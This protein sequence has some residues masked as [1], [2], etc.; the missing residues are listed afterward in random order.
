VIELKKNNKGFTLIELLAVIVI[1][2][3]IMLVAI[4]S[5]MSSMER[6]KDKQYEA[7]KSIIEAKA[8]LYVSDHKNDFKTTN[9]VTVETLKNEGLLTEKD[10]MD[11]R[12]NNIIINGYVTVTVTQS[13]SGGYIYTYEFTE[14]Q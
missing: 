8:E 5:I 14:A 12:N 2:I 11:P 3:A 1:L 13:T 9:T 10:L 7:V 6:S 4:P